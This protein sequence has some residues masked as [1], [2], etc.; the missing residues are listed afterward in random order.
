MSS[1]AGFPWHHTAGQA[2]FVSLSSSYLSRFL[3]VRL[4][5]WFIY[6]LRVGV[7]FASLVDGWMD[8]AT[9]CSEISPWTLLSVKDLQLQISPLHWVSS[10]SLK[11]MWDLNE[12]CGGQ[13]IER[14]N[15][16]SLCISTSAD[17]HLWRVT[18]LK[19]HRL[20]GCCC[21]QKHW[22]SFK[23]SL[24]LW[25]CITYVGTF[26]GKAHSLKKVQSSRYEDTSFQGG[27]I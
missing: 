8:T 1:L 26:F 18:H 22:M 20:S 17:W 24:P 11:C 21:T 4:W 10:T 5:P 19:Y 14:G 2:L 23:S 27:L 9:S 7:V 13:P 12:D 16:T 3:S 6:P 15:M 25:T